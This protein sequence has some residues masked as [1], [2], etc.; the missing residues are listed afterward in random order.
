MSSHQTNS[1]PFEKVGECLYRYKPSG[2]YYARLKQNGKEIRCSLETTDR[3][4]AKKNKAMSPHNLA[5]I[6]TKYGARISVPSLN[7]L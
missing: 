3:F 7:N 2:V 4:L 1:G 5:V 6:A